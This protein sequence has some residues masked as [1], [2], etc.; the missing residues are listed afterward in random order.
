MTAVWIPPAGHM[1]FRA[2]PATTGEHHHDAGD[3][4]DRNGDRTDDHLSWYITTAACRG[5]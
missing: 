1:P 5:R 3:R 2:V 4:Q